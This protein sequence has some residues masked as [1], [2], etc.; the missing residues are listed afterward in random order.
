MPAVRAGGEKVA[1]MLGVEF[2]LQVDVDL[3]YDVGRARFYKPG[4]GKEV[5]EVRKMQV[6][7]YRYGRGGRSRAREM[8][9]RTYRYGRGGRSR[10]RE[11]L[12]RSR[13]ARRDWE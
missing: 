3:D 10:A 5:A 8:Q 12:R 2:L 9:V 4:K 13:T 1:G 11:D 7:A 6:R